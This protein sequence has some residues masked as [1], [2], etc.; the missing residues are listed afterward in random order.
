VEKLVEFLST[1][2]TIVFVGAGVSREVGIPAWD[3]LAERLIDQL[4]KAMHREEAQRLRAERKYPRLM[5]WIAARQGSPWLYDKCRHLL[6]DTTQQGKIA[7]FIATYPFRG[8]LTTNFDASLVRHFAAAARPVTVFGN[9]RGDLEQVDMDA[10]R[11]LIRVHSDLDHVETLVLTEE[12]YERA[13]SNDD[14]KYLRDWIKAYFMTSRILF[15][16]YSLTDPEIELILEDG[17]Q[18]FRKDPP[19]HAVL[20]NTS[21]SDEERLR[22]KYNLEVIPYRDS[23]GSHRELIGMVGVLQALTASGPLKPREPGLD[24]RKA[25]SLYLWSKFALGGSDRVAQV[26]SLK[27]IVLFQLREGPQTRA[28]LFS[29]VGKLV[30]F[31]GEELEKTLDQALT[32]L[33]EEG[34]VVAEGTT[35]RLSVASAEVVANAT[36]QHDKLRNAFIEETLADLGREWADVGAQARKAATDAALVALVEIFDELGVDIAKAV[37]EGATSRLG[38]SVTLFSILSRVGQTLGTTELRYRFVAYV[39]KLIATPREMQRAYVDH[40]AL[41]FF[42]LHALQMDPEGHRFRSS[43]LKERALLVDGNVL[44]QLLPIGGRH[45]LEMRAVVSFARS[46]GIP[47]LTTTSM[48]DE[49]YRHA[50]RATD[51]YNEFGAQSVQLLEASTGERWNPFLDGYVVVTADKP[52]SLAAY[53]GR[54]VGA[55]YFTKPAVQG[56]LEREY[57]IKTFDFAAL[58]I[59]TEQASDE[60]KSVAAFLRDEAEETLRDRSDSR[61]N[62][63]SEA[64]TIAALRWSEASKIMY[65][66]ANNVPT[67]ARILSK[68]LFLNRVARAGPHPINRNVVVSPEVLYGFLLRFGRSPVANVSFRELMVSPLF[69]SSSHFVDKDRY[70]LFF[71]ELIQ[72]S[73][74]VLREHLDAFKDKIDSGLTT[75]ALDGVEPLR[76]PVVVA[77]LQARLEERLS[78]AEAAVTEARSRATELDTELKRALKAKERLEQNVQLSAD[79]KKRRATERARRK[80]E[81]KRKR[82][83]HKRG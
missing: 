17:G 30:G 22:R 49:V 21:R 48:V 26:D 18:N 64:Y 61:M 71:R 32:V 83:G 53:L 25:Q 39:S 7:R 69:D 78:T 51:I 1:G 41:T 3:A 34:H 24:L 77:G 59:Q 43:Y 44:L 4:P 60:Q 29:R 65:G 62:A 82:R 12:Q 79:R 6:A 76:K 45:H 46:Q 80:E 72:G 40:L 38:A 11:S 31:T 54:C 19:P 63:E 47:L 58:T 52:E 50:A 35:M 74:K 13:R 37:F 28:E 67:D 15:V 68:G 81:S 8:V 2:P 42:S 70:G 55:K 56:F 75:E 20:P 27:S 57:G 10:L 23:D 5:S 9:G 16:G 66:S 14:M 73:E 36:G 33:A